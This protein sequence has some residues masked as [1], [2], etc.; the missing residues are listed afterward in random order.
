MHRELVEERQWIGEDRFLHALSYCTLIPGPE[1]QQLAIYLGWLLS[2][3][4]GGLLAG[5]LFVIPGYLAIMALSLIY[6]GF[7]D[8]ALV[9]ALFAGVA[10]A[11]LAIVTQAVLRVGRRALRNRLLIGV[12]VGAFVALFVFGLPFPV[13]LATAALIGYVSGRICPTLFVVRGHSPNRP[14]EWRPSFPTPT[15]RTLNH[16]FV[17]SANS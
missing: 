10:P 16:P 12:A 13:L 4:A 5:V 15:C 14:A 7:G 9:T 6:A 11:V 3:T 17:E 8:T 2:G 1:A